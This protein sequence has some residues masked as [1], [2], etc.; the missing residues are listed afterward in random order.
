MIL[1]ES[2]ACGTPFVATPVG[3][4]TSLRGG[5]HACGTG[6]ITKAIEKLISN[7]SLWMEYSMNGRLH[8]EQCYSYGTVRHQLLSAIDKVL[9]W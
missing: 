9:K 3:A 4:V 7:H 2:M 6:G 8:F 1:L 5:V